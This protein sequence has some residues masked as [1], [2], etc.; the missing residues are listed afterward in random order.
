M[1]FPSPQGG[2][3]ILLSVWTMGGLT[4]FPSPQGGSETQDGGTVAGMGLQ[5]SI[6]SR[7]VG[8]LVDLAGAF[9][10]R[11]VFPSPQGGSETTAA[12]CDCSCRA[13]SFHPLKAGRR[14][15]AVGVASS[16]SAMSFHPLKAGR[17]LDDVLASI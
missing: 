9:A 15:A 2:S 13:N 6:P 8:D 12:R 5:V 1:W 14:L 17:R 7:R 4:G 10:V 16:S 3:E 11:L